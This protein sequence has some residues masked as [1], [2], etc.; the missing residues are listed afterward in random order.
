MQNIPIQREE[1]REI[2]KAFIAE[3]GNI[4]ISADY[5]QI[6]LRVLAHMSGDE[7]LTY[8]FNN[9]IDVHSQTAREILDLSED[10]ELTSEDRR[11]G[12]L[13]NFGIV[14]GMSGF[15]LAKELSIPVGVAQQYINDYFDHFSGVKS[16]FNELENQV[17][18]QSFV[19]TLWGRKRYLSEIDSSSRDKGFIKRV[20]LNAPI[21]GTA[22]DIVKL[23][24][25]KLDDRIKTEK[26]PIKMLLQIHDELVFE[27]P[28]PVK[29]Q[30]LEII[31]EEMENVAKFSVPLKVDIG[32][33]AN[34]KIAH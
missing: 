20:A 31:R 4:I 7:A 22:A 18:T 2:R 10:D 5:S 14:Y 23:A 6:E 15:R 29:D 26:I 12:K 11:A 32:Y 25:I 24:M 1:G 30:A 19:E 33:G 27:C 28:E 21:Q 9:D 13:I 3:K 17:D 16:F 8:A 34:W